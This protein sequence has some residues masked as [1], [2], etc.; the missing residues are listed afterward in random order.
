[1]I[2]RLRLIDSVAIAAGA[3]LVL[4]VLGIASGSF[5]SDARRAPVHIAT[6]APKPFADVLSRARTNFTPEVN[7]TGTLA[8]EEPKGESNGGT[9]PT[10]SPSAPPSTSEADR[11]PLP[12]SPSE[13]ALLERLGERRQEMQQKSKDLD[14][15]ERMLEDAERK[16]EARLNDLK[17]IEQ[18][19]ESGKPGEQESGSLKNLVIMYEAM[20]PKEAA[21]VFD[22]LSH[23]VLVPVVLQMN[24]RKMAEVLAVMAPESAERLTVALALRA[25]GKTEAAPA[26]ASAAALPANELPA[27][28]PSAPRR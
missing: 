9:K 26:N 24:P 12:Q 21:R 15:R 25:R 17:S 7:V 3:M 10:V 5:A 1:M 22:R 28:V 14:L 6:D 27:I 19:V 20:K 13:R 8:K 23:D 16:L 18:K 4:K 11:P 2:G